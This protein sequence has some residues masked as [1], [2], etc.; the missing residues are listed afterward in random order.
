MSKRA[1]GKGFVQE[2]LDRVMTDIVL[3]IPIGDSSVDVILD[4][5]LLG[6]VILRRDGRTGA[7]RYL[8]EVHRILKPSGLLVLE[9][10]T[11]RPRRSADE[12]SEYA[13][14]LLGELFAVK[15]SKA[16][17]AD[18]YRHIDIAHRRGVHPALFL[19]AVKK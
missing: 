6:S 2:L 15:L 16:I 11:L 1:E 5:W 8:A 4:V 18:Y 10:E 14:G 12:L 9:F 7:R 19:V 3:G 13:A 17:D